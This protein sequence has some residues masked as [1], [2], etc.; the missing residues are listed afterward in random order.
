MAA[1]NTFLKK[2]LPYAGMAVVVILVGYFARQNHNNFEKIIVDQARQ[3]LLQS[4]R[5]QVRLLDHEVL[6]LT[7]E[8]QILSENTEV[9]SAF[10]DHGRKPDPAF[11]LLEDSYKDVRSLADSLS[12]VDD[13]GAVLFQTPSR[14]NTKKDLSSEPDV[15]QGLSTRRVYA[16]GV[17]R[18]FSG[19]L[20]LDYDQPV[21]SQG[22]FVGLLRAVVSLEALQSFVNMHE[23][24][25]TYSFLMDSKGDLLSY[26]DVHYLGQNLSAVFQDNGLSFQKSSFSSLFQMSAKGREGSGECPLFPLDSPH[27]AEETIVAFAPVHFGGH[28]WSF[29]A[30]EDYDFFAAPV[31]RNARDNILF[32]G[33]IIFMVFLSA[34]ALYQ[35]QKNKNEELRA[36][37]SLLIQSAKME[38]VGKL[39]AGVAHEVKNPL[40]IILMSL[41]YLKNNVGS[42][43]EDVRSSL[44][45]AENAVDRADTIIKGLLDFSASSELEIKT[46][47]IHVLIDR[48]LLLVKHP[49]VKNNIHVVKNF[50][51]DVPVVRMDKNKAEQVFVNLF[52]NAI[53][54]MPSG[55][56]LQVRTFRASAG[57]KRQMVVVQ[58]EDDGTGLPA[59]VI[60]DLFLPFVTTKRATGGTGLGLSIVRNIMDL[61]GGKI[62]LENRPGG[63]GVRAM[64]WFQISEE[65]V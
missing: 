46:Q 19:E 10:E 62:T 54:A 65:A 64:L 53:Q 59:S 34:A 55:G 23:G 57:L 58:I 16:S 32:G 48:A 1:M 36:T 21:F 13:K 9:Q 51:K 37:Q 43:D 50:G 38:V 33:I 5:V 26:P 18:T 27:K 30:A 3:Q 61:H 4:A 45:D 52:M 17:L 47:D 56:E 28:V 39:A 11:M 63:R 2:V 49:Q 29:V 42:Q 20:V 7:K 40:A 31:N 8:L 22:R 24:G 60:K 15:R 44:S 35:E 41:D 6:N 12:M 14:E 25:E